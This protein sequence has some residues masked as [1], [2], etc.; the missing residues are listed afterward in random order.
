MGFGPMSIM[1]MQMKEEERDEK[2]RKVS[3]GMIEINGISLI[4]IISL[5]L[6]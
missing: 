4:N 6:S 2:M 3:N 1:E 5:I